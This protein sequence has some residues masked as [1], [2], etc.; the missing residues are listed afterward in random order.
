MRLG[1]YLYPFPGLAQLMTEK[2]EV[3]LKTC[4]RVQLKITF[5]PPQLLPIAGVRVLTRAAPS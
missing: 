4:G 1:I 3:T 2:G 5:S